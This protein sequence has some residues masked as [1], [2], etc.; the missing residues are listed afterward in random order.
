MWCR[1]E[2]RRP[3]LRTAS[4]FRNLIADL[5]VELTQPQ[6]RQA[7]LECAVAMRLSADTS[8]TPETHKLRRSISHRP[9]HQRRPRTGVPPLTRSEDPERASLVSGLAECPRQRHHKAHTSSEQCHD[10]N[11]HPVERTELSWKSHRSKGM[12]LRIPRTTNAMR[13][14]QGGMG[15]SCRVSRGAVQTSAE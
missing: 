5:L 15:A 11:T 6:L 2:R 3:R 12:T 7:T 8:H 13:P 10:Q 1:L 9:G 14:L 4:V